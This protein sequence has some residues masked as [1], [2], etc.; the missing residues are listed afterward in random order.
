MFAPQDFTHPS[1]GM[2]ITCLICAEAH[3]SLI[4]KQLTQHTAHT[5]IQNEVTIVNILAQNYTLHYEIR[6]LVNQSD[7][8]IF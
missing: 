7:G 6:L 8:C 1:G 2:I 4:P 5:H 3:H